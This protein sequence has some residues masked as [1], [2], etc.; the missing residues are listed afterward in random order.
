[1]NKQQCAK[2]LSAM[3]V[4]GLL[5][6][7]A[8]PAIGTSPTVTVSGTVLTKDGDFAPEGLTVKLYSFAK[9]DVVASTT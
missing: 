6:T 1:M 9:N 2:L 7:I 8:V 5:A 3:L 4:L